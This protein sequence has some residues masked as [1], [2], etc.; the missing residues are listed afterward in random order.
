[1]FGK[2]LDKL[3]KV[4]TFFEDWTLFI[5]V[6]VALISLFVSVV[7]RYGFNYTMAWSEELIR[8]VIVYTTL[9]GCSSG[10]KK[11]MMIKIDASVQIFPKLKVPLTFFSNLMMLIFA[12]MMIYYGWILAV[13]QAR[14]EQSTII[15]EIPLVY[16]YSMMPLMGVLILLRLIHVFYND[17]MELLDKQPPELNTSR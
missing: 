9:I 11:G 14:T 3:D 6:I 8:E 10:V 1:M 12:I 16:L 13:M 15:L 7:L 5:A 17:I 2:I 4:L